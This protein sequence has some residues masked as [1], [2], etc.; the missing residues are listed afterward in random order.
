MN[1]STLACL[2]LALIFA[3]V[4]VAM[5]KIAHADTVENVCGR[6]FSTWYQYFGRKQC[7]RDRRK[8]EKT[9][10]CLS[11]DVERMESLASEI[12]NG[13]H[14][15]MSLPDV[16]KAMQ[17][18]L[19]RK[20]S[21]V[22]AKDDAEDRVVNTV[23]TT[24][25]ASPFQFVIQARAAPSGELRYVKIWSKFPPS[26]YP[27]GYL[28]KQSRDFETDRRHRQ[29]ERSR[30]AAEAANKR[31]R[32]RLT[33]EAAKRRAQEAARMRRETEA[34]KIRRA[35]AARKHLE[36]LALRK[37]EALAAPPPE[38]GHCASNLAKHE[39]IRRL[40]RFGVVRR[41][42]DN[43]FRAGVHGL[44]FTAKGGGLTFCG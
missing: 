8:A 4:L 14:E 16:K 31:V 1:A 26:G 21:I 44:D 29:M 13:I 7:V 33:A 10:N 39:R 9:R 12:K 2:L 6:I 18:V 27:D 41:V 25:C 11:K 35:E 15:K 24:D 5:P 36:M 38:K 22:R 34:A 43:R 17:A 20:L 19:G 3:A 30:R 28:P 40:Q 37:R 42:G 23:I 32:K